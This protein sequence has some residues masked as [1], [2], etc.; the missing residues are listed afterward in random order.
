MS[1]ESSVSV[2]TLTL[3]VGPRDHAL[4]EESAPV[5]LLEYGDFECPQCGQA[6]PIVQQIRRAFGARLRYVF[7][8]FPL[9]NAHP[10][11]QHAAECAEWAAG[12]GAF[13]PMHDALYGDQAHLADPHLLGR[14]R[15]LGLDPAGLERAWAAHTFIP[16]IKE[17][18]LSGI[19]S[20]VDGTPAFFINGARHEG[21]WDAGG[22]TV[23]IERQLSDRAAGPP[24]P[25]LPA[26]GAGPPR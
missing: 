23:A 18:F 16:R 1:G 12:Q 6:F 2:P 25:A 9:T 21:A 24:D 15:A 5:T 7:R 20:G 8:H 22:L 11:A 4:G 14:A 13:W 10:H 19:R 3:P 26:P 17:D